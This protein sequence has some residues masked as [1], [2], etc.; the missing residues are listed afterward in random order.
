M[1]SCALGSCLNASSCS[2]TSRSLGRPTRANA[3]Q[4]GPPT[5]TSKASAVLPRP[6]SRTRS[7]GF[8]LVMS[9][10]CACAG[11]PGW[12]LCPCD[13]AASGSNST[14]AA[15]V[16]PAAVKPSEMPPQPANRSSTRG[17]PPACR[18]AI[19]WRMARAFVLMGSLFPAWACRS[20]EVLLGCSASALSLLPEERVLRFDVLLYGIAHHPGDGHL[21]LLGDPF[22]FGVEVRRERH[23][24]PGAL[25]R[26]GVLLRG[27]CHG[28]LPLV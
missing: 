10:A 14:A 20:W 4:G 9:R 22:E 18:R 28:A 24:R 17:S 19:F 12:K 25:L 6:S 27:D 13:A 16:K 2:S 23:G 7:S 26:R 21:L 15:T 8:V 5:S 1:Y 3:W 11:S